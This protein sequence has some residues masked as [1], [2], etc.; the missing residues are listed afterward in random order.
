MIAARVPWFA[1]DRHAQV[2][3][4]DGDHAIVVVPDEHDA[5]DNLR[6]V[7]EVEILDARSE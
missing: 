3:G 7:F 4:T 2:I 5:I 6:A 1:L